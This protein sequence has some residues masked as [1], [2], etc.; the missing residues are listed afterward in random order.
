MGEAH[1]R[2]Q[3]G[4]IDEKPWKLCARLLSITPCLKLDEDVLDRFLGEF[5]QKL[6]DL[7]CQEL[8]KL[9]LAGHLEK[10]SEL[11]RPIWKIK[12]RPADWVASLRKKIR[13]FAVEKG[14]K[15]DGL[16]EDA[17]EAHI[18]IRGRHCNTG[19]EPPLPSDKSDM[20]ITFQMLRIRPRYTEES[21]RRSRT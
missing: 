4:W 12:S 16:I 18:T 2:A 7:A 21:D 3:G 15:V 1:L 11:D 14:F 6:T 20:R 10:G 19:S 13:V 8:P 9:E 17:T 5:E